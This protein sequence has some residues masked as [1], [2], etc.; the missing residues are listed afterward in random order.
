VTLR[1]LPAESCIHVSLY[2]NGKSYGSIVIDRLR[3]L[4]SEALAEY[5]NLRSCILAPLAGSS[6]VWVAIDVL[7]QMGSGAAD[8]HTPDGRKISVSRLKEELS[9]WL[10]SQCEFNFILAEKLRQAGRDGFPKMLRL[11]DM[12]EKHPDWVVRRT[13]NFEQACLSSRAC[14]HCSTSARRSNTSFTTSCHCRRAQTRRPPNRQSSGSSY[15][16]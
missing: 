10:T 15:P 4:V 8:V 11:Q 2:S 12:R 1:C 6:E 14:S 5:R 7:T 16:T 3:T 9:L 13:I